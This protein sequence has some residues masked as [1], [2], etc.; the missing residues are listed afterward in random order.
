MLFR[1]DEFRQLLR[2]LTLFDVNAKL[3][4][5]LLAVPY[6]ERARDAHGYADFA[7]VGWNGVSGHR[8]IL[9]SPAQGDSTEHQKRKRARFG[10]H[11]SGERPVG[12]EI[13]IHR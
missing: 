12:F 4:L 13:E 3:A 7:G 6:H 5:A 9:A 8:P 2:C 11:R 10:N 1:I